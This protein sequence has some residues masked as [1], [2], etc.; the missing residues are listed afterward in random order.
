MLLVEK[1]L[2]RCFGQVDLKGPGA[3]AVVYKT[4]VVAG[5][6]V[7]VV[8]GAAPPA[9]G[10]AD[11]GI[12]S[13]HTD[14]EGLAFHLCPQVGRKDRYLFSGLKALAGEAIGTAPAH[15]RTAVI[16]PEHILDGLPVSLFLAF[17]PLFCGIVDFEKGEAVAG[18]EQVLLVKEIEERC[19]GQ[20]DLKGIS[21]I[22]VVYQAVVIAGLEVLVVQ[23]TAPPAGGYT[24]LGI[25]SCNVNVEGLCLEEIPHVGRDDGNLLAGL[26][27][28][29]CETVLAAP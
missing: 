12:G 28:L 5:L 3:V 8:Q 20:V 4:V 22:P 9:G 17:L 24:D 29:A 2:E 16:C 1:I 25:G 21:S 11:L 7:L 14:V 6:E 26:E 23:R 10:N 18:E 19:V 15:F 13:L 27:A